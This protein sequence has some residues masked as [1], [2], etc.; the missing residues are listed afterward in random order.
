MLRNWLF[1]VFAFTLTACGPSMYVKE[2]TDTKSAMI[3][4]YISASKGP[5]DFQWVQLRHTDAAGNE[6]YYTTRADE[7][8]MFYAENLPLGQYQI[9]RMGN[10][11]TPMGPNVIGG[12]GV[13]WS[14][15][16]GSKDTTIQ[17]K[18]PGARYMGSFKYTY[19]EG[20]GFFGRDSFTF[21]RA[22]TPPEK[23]LLQ[24]L[25]KYTENTHWQAS[26]KKRLAELQ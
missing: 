25:I 19:V 1:I 6:D 17:V 18:K 12:G 7:D 5:M 13:V 20:K 23:E 3:F 24:R 2:M 26:V 8:G 11:N 14:L 15:A 21:D 4:G 10:G 9:H 22:A 16:E